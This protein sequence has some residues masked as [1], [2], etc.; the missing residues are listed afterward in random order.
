[1]FDDPGNV[2]VIYLDIT[3]LS[4]QEATSMFYVVYL[5]KGSWRL[6]QIAAVTFLTKK[7]K[8]WLKED[9][10]C[11]YFYRYFYIYMISNSYW[12][13]YLNHCIF[14]RVFT[15]TCTALRRELMLDIY[16]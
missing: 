11:R 8:S 15:V 6:A 3:F 4:E 9:Q 5:Y 14:L 2:D 16:I 7:V 1:M 13:S 10:S 12:E